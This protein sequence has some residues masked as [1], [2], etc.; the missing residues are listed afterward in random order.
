MSGLN[1]K[2]NKTK[3]C[4]FKYQCSELGIPKFDRLDAENALCLLE[5]RLP[6]AELYG[7][8]IYIYIY[9]YVKTAEKVNML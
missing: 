6:H 8:H 5:H 9:V 2:I 1:N 4:E 3:Q 7:T